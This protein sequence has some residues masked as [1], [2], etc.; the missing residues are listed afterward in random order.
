[1]NAFIAMQNYIVKEEKDFGL[2]VSVTLDENIAKYE[3]CRKKNV[4]SLNNWMLI[5]IPSSETFLDLNL[6]LIEQKAVLPV[7]QKKEFITNIFYHEAKKLLDEMGNMLHGRNVKEESNKL[8][9]EFTKEKFEFLMKFQNGQKLFDF[10]KSKCITKDKA[11][12]SALLYNSGISGFIFNNE[13]GKRFFLYNAK[14]DIKPLE[15][16]N[17]QLEKSKLVL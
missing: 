9:E 2:G 11:K 12:T 14:K 13:T 4:M 17:M 8:F 3:S 1:M 15:Y 5:D 6:P 16:R 10:V 7:L